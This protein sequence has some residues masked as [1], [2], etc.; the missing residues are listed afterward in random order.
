[1]TKNTV[2]PTGP[3]TSITPAPNGRLRPT[4]RALHACP[5]TTIAAEMARSPSNDGSRF[6][7]DMPR[8]LASGGNL[9]IRPPASQ[10]VTIWAPDHANRRRIAVGFQSKRGRR[11]DG[12]QTGVPR[13]GI[14]RVLACRDREASGEA[15]A[16]QSDGASGQCVATQGVRE[17]CP[18]LH[19]QAGG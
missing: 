1:M 18:D 13:D 6:L 16:G 12:F 10:A 7:S 9:G 5:K 4:C 2:T 17:R 14:D 11:N 15:R 8:P 19:M 3:Q